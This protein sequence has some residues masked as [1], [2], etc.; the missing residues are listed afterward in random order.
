MSNTENINSELIAAAKLG[1]TDTVRKLLAKGADV[2]A[3]ERIT[4][5]AYKVSLSWAAVGGHTV[6]EKSLEEEAKVN[7]KID[8]GET[9]LIAA[10]GGGHTATV[11]LLLE[12]SAD[13]NTK[14][15]GSKDSCTALMKA[16][17]GGHTDTVKM[18]LEKGA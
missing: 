6:T 7:A 5:P 4:M 12:Q 15:G 11:K 2:N 14:G 13:V 18:L 16:A 3:L 1:N 9:A 17:Q 8:Y 10:A